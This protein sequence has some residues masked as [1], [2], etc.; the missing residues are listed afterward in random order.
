MRNEKCGMRNDLEEGEVLSENPKLRTQTQNL[1][2]GE[3]V[4]SE[5]LTQNFFPPDAEQSC[6]QLERPTRLFGHRP[7]SHPHTICI[8][9]TQV[10]RLK[11]TVSTP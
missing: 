9:T 5:L 11:A 7:D 4:Y 3:A 6:G 2:L 1:E 10:F 8:V